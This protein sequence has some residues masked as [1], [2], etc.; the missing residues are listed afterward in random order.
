[1]VIGL[2]LALPLLLG[3]RFSPARRVLLLGLAL[4]L[5]IAVLGV[6]LF[7]V[8]STSASRR[9]YV[10]GSSANSEWDLMIDFNGR[11]CLSGT[12][13]VAPSSG[14]PARQAG[15]AG[16]LRL[17]NRQLGGQ[18][19]WLLP[20]ALAGLVHH[21]VA[22]PRSVREAVMAKQFDASSIKP[23]RWGDV[24]KLPSGSWLAKWTIELETVDSSHLQEVTESAIHTAAGFSPK[25]IQAGSTTIAMAIETTRWSM[26]LDYYDLTY[27]LLKVIDCRMGRILMVQG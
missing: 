26:E 6:W 12:A 16:P 11:A 10:E 3:A 19:G 22:D 14:P 13:N 5:A 7:A 20:L 25:L 27:Q 1:M 17:V 18:I 8:D 4:L 2:G 24:S 15:P 21:N 23:I 9:P